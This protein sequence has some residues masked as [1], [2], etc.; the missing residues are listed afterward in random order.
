MAHLHNGSNETVTHSLTEEN[1]QPGVLHQVAETTWTL[2]WNKAFVVGACVGS[3]L[4]YAS[5]RVAQHYL[6]ESEP[7]SDRPF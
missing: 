6:S 2:V 7:D 5:L 1:I 3:V 4:M